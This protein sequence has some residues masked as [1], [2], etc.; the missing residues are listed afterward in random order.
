MGFAMHHSA[1]K[2]LAAARQLLEEADVLLSKAMRRVVHWEEQKQLAD[3]MAALIL[4]VKLQVR[5]SIAELE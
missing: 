2:E 4:K 3:H 1:P 5:A